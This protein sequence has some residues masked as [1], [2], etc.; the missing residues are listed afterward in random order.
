[1][2]AAPARRRR[3]RPSRRRARPDRAATGDD[4]TIGAAAG[5]PGPP[6]RRSHRRHRSRQDDGATGVTGAAGPTRPARPGLVRRRSRL[7]RQDDA[8][9]D[10]AGPARLVDR[11]LGLLPPAHEPGQPGLELL[12][13]AGPLGVHLVD[14]VRGRPHRRGERP[15]V[16][17]S[18]LRSLMVLD[19]SGPI[20][21]R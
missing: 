16:G 15:R 18:A 10:A 11:A 5:P 13:P 4:G 20:T 14:P 19:A 6:V 17:S 3:H 7:G 12:D 21:V 9:R 1:M 8:L 2:V